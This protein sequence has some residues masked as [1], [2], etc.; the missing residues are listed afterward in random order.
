MMHKI[1][2]VVVIAIAILS[3]P[4]FGGV[5]VKFD[6]Q[7][8]TF[9]VPG[10]T[11]DSGSIPD[12]V[13]TGKG[14]A[15]PVRIGCN[16]AGWS[17]IA[18]PKDDAELDA[19]FAAYYA[20]PVTKATTFYAIWEQFEPSALAGEWS[21]FDS[22]E[23]S[24]FQSVV[25]PAQQYY[26]EEWDD[27][28]L[29]SVRA[30]CSYETPGRGWISFKWRVVSAEDTTKELYAE[31]STGWSEYF[32]GQRLI[33]RT[34]SYMDSVAEMYEMNDLEPVY[35]KGWK[36]E[37]VAVASGDPMEYIWEFENIRTESVVVQIADVT[38][39]WAPADTQIIV[40]LDPCGGTLADG[41]QIVCGSIYEGL[42]TPE[43]EGAEFI[44][45]TAEDYYDPYSCTI[46][47][48]GDWTPLADSVTLRAVWDVPVEVALDPYYTIQDDE[49]GNRLEI[50]DMDYYYV[51]TQWDIA[52]DFDGDG[53]PI[54]ETMRQVWAGERVNWQGQLTM[55][56][57][58]DIVRAY[59]HGCGIY[60]FSRLSCWN[61][62]VVCRVYVDGVLQDL[63]SEFEFNEYFSN[64]PGVDVEIREKPGYFARC[65]GLTPEDEDY[66]L[67]EIRVAVLFKG[68]KSGC[69]YEEECWVNGEIGPM[70]WT[71]SPASLEVTFDGCGGIVSGASVR[72]F[73]VGSMYGVL[74]DAERKDFEF[75]GWFTEPDGGEQVLPF[76]LVRLS[77][78]KLYARWKTDLMT[79]LGDG[80]LRYATRNEDWV[81]TADLSHGSNGV[82]ATTGE[83][84]W[85][86]TKVM[87][88]VVQGRGLLSFWWMQ[89]EDLSIMSDDKAS[90]TLWLDGKL[91][92]ECRGTSAWKHMTLPVLGKGNHKVEWKYTPGT[93]YI[94]I[95]DGWDY[96]GYLTPMLAWEEQSRLMR[97]FNDGPVHAPGA[98]VDEVGW[99]PGS[100][101]K[102]I[103]PWARGIVEGR[104]WLTEQLPLIEAE[105]TAKIA[106]E[107]LNYEW[108]VLR[109]ITKLFG[110]G[111]NE[112]LK[113]VLAQFGL[114]PDYQVLGNFFGELDYFDAPLS[115][116]IV[117]ALAAEAVPVL[118]SA[119]AD[120]DAIPGDWTGSIP[121]N[122]AAYPVDVVTYVDLADITLYKA[123]LKGALSA[124]AIAEG[125]DLSVDYMNGEM[126]EILAEAGLPVTF[127]YLVEDHPEFAKRVRDAE[128][129]GEGKE[130]LRDALE[131]LQVFDELMLGRT[132][133][134]MHFFEYDE[135][136]ADKQ[137]YARE[138]VAKMLVALDGE[139]V[140][141]N[142]DF[143]YARNF[144]VSEMN[145]PA[146]LVPFFG[147]NVTRRYLPTEIHG[148]NPVFDSFPTMSFGGTFP[149]LTK[150]TVAG[151]LAE[152]GREVEYTPN[153]D[154]EPEVQF[155]TFNAAIPNLGASATEEEI[156]DALAGT[157]DAKVKANIT[158][159]KSYA[160]YETWATK[161]QSA[162][163]P[164]KAVKASPCSWQSF[165]LAAPEL[166]QGEITD[167]DLKVEE[168]KPSSESGKFDFTV[169][170]KDVTV[171]SEA[172]EENLKQVIGLEGAESLGEV[173]KSENVAIKFGQPEDGKLKFTAEPKNAEAKSFFMKMKVK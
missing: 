120:L 143:R 71:A 88:T 28:Y 54:W 36:T 125:Y 13:I 64:G 135:K 52:Y 67:H 22:N 31:S 56:E 50:G 95:D 113:A 168:F 110:L 124:L 77:T 7:G 172:V 92:A 126:E 148:N 19:G 89:G 51:S 34:Y 108:R 30:A 121:L 173:F 44:G 118:E 80:K 151:W 4:L 2:S 170:V 24:G 74:P 78:T 123:A 103:I 157:A 37:R 70:R 49:R 21:L 97:L 27:Y 167:E 144:A 136:D 145:Q 41:N 156:E 65:D 161:V 82:C 106:D 129:L 122:P 60:H 153:S 102:S 112:N 96:Y 137:Q 6:A 48:D 33:L 61:D 17:S 76:E 91:I 59:V 116:E 109:A 150:D 43:R 5:Y 29:E 127:E 40:T 132:T 130:I 3:L 134:E 147:G 133:S 53:E 166:M 98:W 146:T 94:A 142:D 45:W 39:E 1:K 73:E 23:H 93:G 9:A 171:G 35:T 16:F 38:W 163:V 18:N 46:V 114:A 68:S 63:D 81:G 117:D 66:D 75:L 149:G 99:T 131:T 115:N 101:V 15:D 90:L 69:G 159:A 87:T 12:E 141:S 72:T 57:E 11:M 86:E 32:E 160:A 138:E 10:V 154:Y 8:G 165:A 14:Y 47:G 85:G 26:E 139:T 25:D 162:G 158:D 164:L 20:T 107:P 155:R 62:G 169:S 128:R 83:L 100:E 140:I 84:M 42:P 79:A 104:G 105:Y 119:L 58:R 55:G 152:N 111:E